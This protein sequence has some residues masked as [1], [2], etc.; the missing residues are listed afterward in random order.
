MAVYWVW[1][2]GCDVVWGVCVE[3]K[4]YA[5]MHTHQGRNFFFIVRV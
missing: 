4:L 1:C 2:T 5:H 3:T